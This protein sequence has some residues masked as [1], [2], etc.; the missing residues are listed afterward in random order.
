[1]RLF[2]INPFSTGII[3]NCTQIIAITAA[4]VALQ[5]LIQF[6]ASKCLEH[7]PK[8]MTATENNLRG[9]ISLRQPN[10]SQR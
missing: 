2:E 4:T 1:M 9:Q 7:G 5:L 8:K 6:N 3:V 10:F